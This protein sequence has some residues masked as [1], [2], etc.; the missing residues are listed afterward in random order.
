MVVLDTTALHDKSI[1]GDT[2]SAYVVAYRLCI[3]ITKRSS[4]C[5]HPIESSALKLKHGHLGSF[6]S[7]SPKPHNICR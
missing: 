6:D 5:A 2:K 4:S 7:Q 3:M 1:Q